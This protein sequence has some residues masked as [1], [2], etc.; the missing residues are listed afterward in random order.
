MVSL[1]WMK[2]PIPVI[3]MLEFY[4]ATALVKLDARLY[5]EQTKPTNQMQGA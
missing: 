2:Y 1:Q 3:V 4:I 5:D